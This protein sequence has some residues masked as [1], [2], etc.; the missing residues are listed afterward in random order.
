MYVW[1]DWGHYSYVHWATP[2]R[3]QPPGYLIANK[4]HTIHRIYLLS[5]L[6]PRALPLEE[7]TTTNTTHSYQHSKSNVRGKPPH[8]HCYGCKRGH[9]EMLNGTRTLK[10]Y[11]AW[12]IIIL[13]KYLTYLVLNKHKNWMTN[14]LCL[15]HA[16]IL[17]PLPLFP[18]WTTKD[19]YITKGSN[20][21]DCPWSMCAH[22][23]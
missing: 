18:F 3:S 20:G 16:K 6:I 15:T 22:N 7:K 10:K 4:Y 17:P 9:P 11:T 2:N 1:W 21:Q 5:W 14:N 8:H 12:E 19:D 23:K 13:I